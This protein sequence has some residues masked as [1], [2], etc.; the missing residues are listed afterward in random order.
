MFFPCFFRTRSKLKIEVDLEIKLFFFFKK[1]WFCCF[2][3][4]AP[5]NRSVYLQTSEGTV[6]PSDYITLAVNASSWNEKHHK[7]G[8]CFL[9]RLH[10]AAQENI[11]FPDVMYDRTLVLFHAP[12]DLNYGCIW[13]MVR[14]AC[15]RQFFKCVKVGQQTGRLGRIQWHLLANL[16]YP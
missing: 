10:Q 1:Y 12:C 2:W 5:F 3:F 4:C 6:A 16:H 14:A 7:L 9:H 15:Y 13:D 11:W 8:D